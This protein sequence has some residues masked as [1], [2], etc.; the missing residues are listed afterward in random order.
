MLVKAAM[1]GIKVVDRIPLNQRSL[2][3]VRHLEAGGSVP[4]IHVERH[5]GCWWVL[6]GRHRFVAHKLLGRSHIW[7]KVA[8]R[9]R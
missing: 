4:P 2:A 1:S 3:L 5:D 7:V 6:D 8:E 9:R